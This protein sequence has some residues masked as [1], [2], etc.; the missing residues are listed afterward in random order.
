M[1]FILNASVTLAWGFSD[2]ATATTTSRHMLGL[3]LEMP[4][5]ISYATPIL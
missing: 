2:E 1:G 3:L 5:S 4:T